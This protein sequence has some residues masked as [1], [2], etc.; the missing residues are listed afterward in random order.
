MSVLVLSHRVLA[1]GFR[2]IFL[3]SVLTS[4]LPRPMP[5]KLCRVMPPMLQAARPVEAVTATRSGSLTCFFLRSWM[6]AR[7]RTDLPV[8]AAPVKKTLWP[9]STT[10]LLTWRCSS[11]SVMAADF[12]AFGRERP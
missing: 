6:M 9:L 1:L 3:T 7:I 12:L 2:L 8:P 10:R 5:E 4:S 11:L